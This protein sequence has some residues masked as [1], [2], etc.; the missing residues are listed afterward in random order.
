MEYQTYKSH[1][2]QASS[3]I[4]CFCSVVGGAGSRPCGVF[5]RS[6]YRSLYSFP[7]SNAVIDQRVQVVTALPSLFSSLFKLLS[8]GFTH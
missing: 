7:F 5:L 3:L 6:I 8:N 4:S 1:I 2:D